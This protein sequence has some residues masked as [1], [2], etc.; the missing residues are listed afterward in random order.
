MRFC[1]D[2]NINC[3]NFYY[4][5]NQY[6]YLPISI[7]LYLEWSFL[8]NGRNIFSNTNKYCWMRFSCYFNINTESGFNKHNQYKHLP[9]SFPI[10]LEQQFLCNGRDILCYISKFGWVRFGC[11]FNINTESCFNKH[12]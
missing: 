4:Q 8:R 1:C 9:I 11:Y 12:D 7:P 6:K 2:I 3:K 10:Q 5:H